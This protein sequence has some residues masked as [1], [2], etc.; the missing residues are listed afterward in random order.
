MS[1]Q[2]SS[3]TRQQK[4]ALDWI[5]RLRSG[6]ANQTD[7]AQFKNWRQSSAENECAIRWAIR[8]WNASGA[9]AQGQWASQQPNVVT[10]PQR[11]M[12]AMI[13]RRAM[14]GGA[15]AASAA[16]YSVFNPPLG[17]WPSVAELSA[18]HRT[19]K[20]ERRKVV[21][22]DNISL[23]LNTAT[24]LRVLG[25][26]DQP[27]V[28]L[29][30][31]EVSMDSRLPTD[32]VV[33]VSAAEGVVTASQANFITRCFDDSVSVICVEGFVRVNAGNREVP[34]LPSQKVTLSSTGLGQSITVNTA[35]ET[36][37]KTGTIIY[38]NAPL[39]EVIED[40]NRYRPGK[41]VLLNRDLRGK[42]VNGAFNIGE[43]DDVIRQVQQL[44]GAGVTSLPGGVVLLT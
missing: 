5:V 18:D 13:S 44:F 38:Q 40:I 6:H 27:H 12:P 2:H 25:A 8:L 20:G 1:V 32:R 35:I 15:I 37:W 42:L 43:L 36:S 29:I 24:S 19:A 17:L 3:L 31:G 21:L 39:S 9:A 14:M 30:S 11:S 41:I 4:D 26:G 33:K 34:L 22:D 28:E 10:L 23:E 16:V 7:A